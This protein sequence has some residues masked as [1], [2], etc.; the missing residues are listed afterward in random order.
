MNI[1]E[2]F[3]KQK[4]IILEKKLHWPDDEI[5]AHNHSKKRRVW[6]YRDVKEWLQLDK[7][8]SIAIVAKNNVK[9]KPKK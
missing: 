5:T 2:Y 3:E 6:S 7:N 9:R 8:L 1:S 4:M